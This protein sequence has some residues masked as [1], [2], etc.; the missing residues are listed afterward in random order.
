VWCVCRAA[1]AL[2][3]LVSGCS[4]MMTALT[5]PPEVFKVDTPTSV[6]VGQSDV[7][8]KVGD[9][10]RLPLGPGT[11]TA[12]LGWMKVTINAKP[13]EYPEFEAG[14]EASSLVFRAQQPGQYRVEV[15][16]EVVRRIDGVD[17][18]SSE[19]SSKEEKSL[20]DPIGPD[21]TFTLNADPKWTPR[22][23]NITVVK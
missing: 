15:H 22:V 4:E 8:A 9:V 12:Q 19:E 2:A 20:T 13:Q 17:A 10:L 16:R 7:Q 3:G 1:V 14:E 6:P 11:N 18:E 21:T 5:P 23:W